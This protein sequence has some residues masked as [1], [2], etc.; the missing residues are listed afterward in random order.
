[1]NTKNIPNIS[2]ALLP[3]KFLRT[4]LQICDRRLLGLN[5][6]IHYWDDKLLK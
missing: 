6:H 2:F 4:T 3:F 1:M 5:L